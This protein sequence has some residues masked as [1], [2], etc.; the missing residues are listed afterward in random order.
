MINII[1]N[2]KSTKQEQTFPFFLSKIAFD[3]LHVSGIFLIKSKQ[4]SKQE[5]TK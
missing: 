3:F 5:R 1:L 2:S 4:I